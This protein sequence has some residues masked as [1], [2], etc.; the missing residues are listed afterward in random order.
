VAFRGHAVRN[1]HAVMR[2]PMTIADHHASRLVSDPLRLYDCCLETDGAVALLVTSVERARDCREPP[3]IILAG[4]M[5]GGGHH[6]RLATFYGRSREDD[7]APR[8][9]AQLWEMA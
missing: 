3:A 2:T 7:G 6:I 5:A 1:P 9:A 8:V 4:A